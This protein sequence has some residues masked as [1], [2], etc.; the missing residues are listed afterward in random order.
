MVKILAI[1]DPHGELPKKIPK[2]DLILITGD[3]GKSDLA[4]KIYFTKKKNEIIA[5]KKEQDAAHKEIYDSTIKLLKELSGKKEVYMI[6]GN[7]ATKWSKL[8]RR[9][10]K[11]KRV[12]LVRNSIRKIDG[13]RIGFLEFFVD[14]SWIKEFKEKD[15]NR[16]KRAKRETVKAKKVLKR[17]GSIDILICHQPP[18]GVLDKVN[19]KNGTPKSWKGKHAGSKVILNYIKKYQPKLVLCGHIHEAKGKAKIGKT[20]VINLGCCGDYEVIDIE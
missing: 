16:I 1:G 13:L 2:S 9:I 20:E 3:I 6:M 8:L 18:Y 12:H 7:V 5:S 14:N 11:I 17:F 10:N 15:K 4:K 19:G